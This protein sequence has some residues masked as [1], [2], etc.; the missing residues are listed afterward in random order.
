[1]Y[2]YIDCALVMLLVV[3]CSEGYLMLCVTYKTI[4]VAE[5]TVSL[6]VLTSLFHYIHVVN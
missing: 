2:R 4:Y 3:L 5:E 1:M 6:W